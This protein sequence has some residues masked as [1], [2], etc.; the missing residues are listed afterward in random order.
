M[1]FQEQALSGSPAKFSESLQAH[2][3]NVYKTMAGGI[4]L[5]FVTAWLFA[6]TPALLSLILDV[7]TG[8]PTMLGWIVMFSPLALVL[9]MGF[10]MDS[11]SH[12]KAAGIFYLI[13][14]LIG[15][16]MSSIFLVYTNFSIVQVFLVTSISF[17][18]LSLYG[19]TTKKDLSG[20]ASFLF[21]G[22]IGIVVASILN[23]FIGSGALQFAITIIGVLV[24]AGLTATDTQRI[25][26]DFIRT[27]GAISPAAEALG[28]YLNFINLFQ[29]LLSLMGERE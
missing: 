28:L 27:G 1:N 23:I 15:A 22:L 13:S 6:N 20:I 29:M 8:S 4:F 19:Y 11:M 10:K 14:G 25:K 12:G 3:A 18:A 21:M 26:S 7:K 16:S 17:A 24:F 9:L 2:M 5:T